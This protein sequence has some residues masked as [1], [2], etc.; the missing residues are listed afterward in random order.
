MVNAKVRVLYA[1]LGLKLRCQQWRYQA[2]AH[3]DSVPTCH[4]VTL[5]TVRI[6]HRAGQKSAAADTGDGC[7]IRRCIITSRQRTI[8]HMGEAQGTQASN[9]TVDT[10]R[11]GAGAAQRRQSPA[12]GAAH[13]QAARAAVR[14]A[15]GAAGPRDPRHEAAARL[16]DRAAAQVRAEAA[17]GGGGDAAAARGAQ[18]A[19][20]AAALKRMSPSAGISFQRLGSTVHRLVFSLGAKRGTPQGGVTSCGYLRRKPGSLLDGLSDALEDQHCFDIWTMNPQVVRFKDVPVQNASASSKL[21]GA[22]V[23]HVSAV[24]G[25]R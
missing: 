5:G 17:A 21:Q 11:S 25:V 14:G 23:R 1:G 9:Q 13:A 20:A 4:R 7:R 8:R 19:A 3:Q 12:R 15:A 22:S 16:A 18:A 24:P 2:C 10:H 6:S